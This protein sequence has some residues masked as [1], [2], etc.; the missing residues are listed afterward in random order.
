MP[1][2]LADR[3]ASLDFSAPVNLS[4]ILNMLQQLAQP[5]DCCVKSRVIE[6]LPCVAAQSSTVECLLS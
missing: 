1:L 2:D 5:D 6:L 4:G 3:H